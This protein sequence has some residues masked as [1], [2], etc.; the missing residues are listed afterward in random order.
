MKTIFVVLTFF[1]VSS[2]PAAEAIEITTE[3]SEK[4]ELATVVLLQALRKSHDTNKWEFT[5]KVHINKRSIPHSHPI[6]TLHTRHTSRKQTDQLLSTYIH[7]QIHWHLNYNIDKTNAA[8]EELKTIFKAVP[9][10]FPEGA[11]DESSTYLHLIV[12]Y[13]ELEAIRELLSEKRVNKVTNFWLQDHY[14]WIYRQVIEKRQVVEYVV[15]K[16]GLKIE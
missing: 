9:F 4:S 14:T 1:M 7:E 5:D 6:L 16:Y 12:C 15:L 10:G 2:I 13:L 3:N 8:I 11:R